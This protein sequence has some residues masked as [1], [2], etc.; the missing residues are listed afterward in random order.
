MTLPADLIAS[1]GEALGD[2][3]ARVEAES[4]G[5]INLAARL[6]LV[7]G[8]TVFLKH[9]P[10]AELIEF[11][12][13]VAGLE[14]L[15]AAEALPLPAVLAAGGDPH[16]WL[17]LEWIEPGQVSDPGAERLGRGLA[18]LHRAGAP[19]HGALPPGSPD[20]R[21]RI[22]SVELPPIR[23]EERT[24]GFAAP[25][26]SGPNEG[27]GSVPAARGEAPPWPIFYA[28]RLVMPLVAEARDQGAID[29]AGAKAVGR[30]CDRIEAAAGPTEMPSRL[31]GDLW[32]GNVYADR[33][34]DPWLI[35]PAAYGG[36]REIDLAML[37]LFG[38]PG[39]KRVFAAYEEEWPLPEG[40]EQRVA[41][42]QLFPL[43][44][45]AVLF[46][47]GYGSRAVTAARC[48]L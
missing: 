37:R 17:A 25:P 34:G 40:H 47:G 2:R 11:Q 20:T 3:V 43:L 6:E 44:V 10:D 18:R 13:E 46:G 21:L 48:Y 36:H 12:T 15:R 7:S 45:H 14:W 27:E 29:A 30:L 5:S 23:E 22:G 24:P 33:N 26:D 39:G 8:R 35:D 28:E 42:W 38:T 19:A 9:R 31:H 16:A 4:G 32:G 1:V 41:L